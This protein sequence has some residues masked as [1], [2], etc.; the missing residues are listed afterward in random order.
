MSPDEVGERYPQTIR[1]AARFG[2]LN[3]LMP[4]VVVNHPQSLQLRLMRLNRLN[5]LN[6]ALGS[7]QVHWPWGA[8]RKIGGIVAALAHVTYQR[9]K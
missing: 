7:G 9:M 1:R 8:G 5:R 4:E 6:Q 3:Y 2:G